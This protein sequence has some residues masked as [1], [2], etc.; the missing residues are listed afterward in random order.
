MRR[1]T[2]MAV[3]GLAALGGLA[4]TSGARAQG[5]PKVAGKHAAGSRLMFRIDSDR[6]GFLSNGE[7]AAGRAKLMPRSGG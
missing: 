1:T 3:A 5:K 6:D 4:M 7:L 2:L